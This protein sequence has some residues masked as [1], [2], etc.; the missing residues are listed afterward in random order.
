MFSIHLILHTKISTHV[1]PILPLSVGAAD[2]LVPCKSHPLLIS[3]VRQERTGVSPLNTSSI[4]HL[5]ELLNGGLGGPGARERRRVLDYFAHKS[6]HA[7][8]F[9]W[10]RY[11]QILEMPAIITYSEIGMGGVP[12]W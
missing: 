12:F 2:C 4:P 6:L 9:L 8:Q 11:T 5:Y 3:I 10:G 1:W 7:L